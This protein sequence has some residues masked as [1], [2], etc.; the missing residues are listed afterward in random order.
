M[1]ILF[2][3]PSLIRAG[4]ETQVIELV[5][6]LDPN[7]FQKHLYT[8]ERNIDLLERLDK[9]NVT[10]CNNTRRYKFDINPA[11]AIG[12]LIDNHKIDVVHCSLQ[13]ALMMAWL[14]IRFSERKPHLVVALHT[15]RNRNLKNEF[16]DRFIYQWLMRSAR[17]VV[18]VC[19][20]QADHWK[21][22]YPFLNG[23]TR[24]IYNGVDCEYFD[25]KNEVNR[26]VSLRSELRIPPAAS[27]VCNIAAFRPEKGHAILIESFQAMLRRKLDTY[28]ILAGD[29]PLRAEIEKMV[30]RRGIGEKIKFLGSLS[31]IRPVLAASD[32]TVIAST[33]VESFPMVMLE[34]MAMSRPV[35]ATDIGGIR[36]AVISG[37]TGYVVP[38]HDPNLLA[39]SILRILVDGDLHKTMGEKARRVVE[40]KFTRQMMI[41][42]TAELLSCV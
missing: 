4:A 31:D 23:M 40:E 19:E 42:N 29:G 24:V 11:M 7:Y 1:R 18:C 21:K 41:S 20:T 26:G 39:D 28:L 6:G 13:I 9:D 34:S 8:F 27:V 3:L 17:A 5:N 30:N 2:V 16:L 33:A 38:T 12:E 15:T 22:K 36:E 10:F 35:V 32:V 25:L 14:G 37:E